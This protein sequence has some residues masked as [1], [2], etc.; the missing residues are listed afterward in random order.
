[1]LAPTVNVVAPLKAGLV[2]LWI[3]KLFSLLA[4]SVHVRLILSWALFAGILKAVPVKPD[5]VAGAANKT[6]A[7]FDGSDEPRVLLM[8]VT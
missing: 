2:S 8:A 1:M 4:L 5:G 3:W 7:V 6:V